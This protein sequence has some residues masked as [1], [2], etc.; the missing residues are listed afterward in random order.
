MIIGLDVSTSVVGITVLNDKGK[1]ISVDHVDLRKISS[2]EQAYK[3]LLVHKKLKEI[4]IS[5]EHHQHAHCDWK[6]YIEAAAKKFGARLSN[7]DTIFTLARF[8]G[9]VSYCAYD[10]FG[11]EP[12]QIDPKTAR[13][14][15]WVEI[16]KIPKATKP[17]DR[18]KLIKQAIIDYTLEFQTEEEMGYEKTRHDNFH[19]WCGD[20]ADSYV[21][22]KAGLLLS[23]KEKD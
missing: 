20:R 9:A 17:Y 11:I 21:I 6:V 4:E 14:T 8:N 15:A 22:A 12:I 18:K 1:L 13:K 7:A 23:K 10:V 19:E 5:A 16:P 3:A 2:E